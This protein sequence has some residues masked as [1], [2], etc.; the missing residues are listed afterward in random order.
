M[1]FSDKYRD[2]EC[3][4][5]SGDGNHLRGDGGRCEW[6]GCPCDF[7]EINYEAYFCSEECERAFERPLSRWTTLED[8]D[9][10]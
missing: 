7:I 1:K 10:A 6:C 5:I 9:G 4:E 2:V 8:E 3:G